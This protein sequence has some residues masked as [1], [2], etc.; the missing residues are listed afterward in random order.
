MLAIL[1][2]NL[3]AAVRKT[4]DPPLRISGFQHGRD[5]LDFQVGF[6]TGF[7]RESADKTC[8]FSFYQ[9]PVAQKRLFEPDLLLAQ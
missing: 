7:F 8:S 9:V 4:A 2:K 5:S 3:R 6:H 1:L